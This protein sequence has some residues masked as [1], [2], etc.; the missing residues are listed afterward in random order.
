VKLAIVLVALSGCF[1][2]TIK[3][4]EPVAPP[5]AE[6]SDRWHHGL[7]FGLAELSGPYDLSKVC[8]KGWAEIHTE[9]TFLQTFITIATINVYAPQNVT[10]R[11]R[12]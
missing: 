8:P 9:T 6:W 1:R 7:V 11:C 10:I 2:T 5:S 12:R 4:G 3:N